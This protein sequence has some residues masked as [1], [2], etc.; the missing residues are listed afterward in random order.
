MKR[1]QRTSVETFYRPMSPLEK[2]RWIAAMSCDKKLPAQAKSLGAALIT[3]WHHGKSGTLC[4][5]YEAITERTGLSR[6]QVKDAFRALKTHGWIE[7]KRQH[8]EKG[9]EISAKR[10]PAW[11]AVVSI[12][13]TESET[14]GSTDTIGEVSTD[15]TEEGSIDTTNRVKGKPGEEEQVSYPLFRTERAGEVASLPSPADTSLSSGEEADQLPAGNPDTPPAAP[16]AD[17]LFRLLMNAPPV[18]PL[19]SGIAVR[20]LAP[21]ANSPA[22]AATRSA[23]LADARAIVFSMPVAQRIA[24]ARQAA[25][26]LGLSDI[27]PDDTDRL[28]EYVALRIVRNAA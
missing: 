27:A 22:E 2:V 17:P 18:E 16:E 5:S 15:T 23:A 28:A 6:Q 3:V 12:D 14:E 1:A 11:P 20:S 24:S 4:P 13:T 10:R 21:S 19:P 25:E 7:S 9:R 26:A 8:D